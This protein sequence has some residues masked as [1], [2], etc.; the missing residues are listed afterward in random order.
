MIVPFECGIWQFLFPERESRITD[1][2]CMKKLI[3]WIK[4]SAGNISPAEKPWSF[5]YNQKWMNYGFCNVSLQTYVLWSSRLSPHHPWDFSCGL[6]TWTREQMAEP[7]A[8]SFWM[9]FTIWSRTFLEK[10]KVQVG[11]Y[12]KIQHNPQK[13]NTIFVFMYREY[14]LSPLS[15][16]GKKYWE[17]DYGNWW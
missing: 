9:G 1:I 15:Q 17:N 5:T 16:K 3:F 7:D 10:I 4:T 11:M 12:R 6:N 8:A 14:F 2:G 13:R